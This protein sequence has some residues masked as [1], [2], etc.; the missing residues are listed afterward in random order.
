MASLI[1]LGALSGF[2]LEVKYL[3][4]KDAGVSF[5]CALLLISVIDNYIIILFLFCFSK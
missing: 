4:K 3:N 2:I 5:I 1:L